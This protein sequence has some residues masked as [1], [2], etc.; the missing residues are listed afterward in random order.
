MCTFIEEFWL[1]MQ[2]SCISWY[3]P[4]GEKYSYVFVKAFL[5]SNGFLFL[6]VL[7]VLN[8]GT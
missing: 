5:L 4:S 2:C 8:A 1:V 7:T 6:D 3:I